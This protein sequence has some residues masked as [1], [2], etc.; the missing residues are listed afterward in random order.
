MIFVLLMAVWGSLIQMG[1]YYRND[2]WLLV[3]LSVAVM[4][5]SI[6]VI[7]EAISVISN[8]KKDGVTGEEAEDTKS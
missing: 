4:I 1:S 2:Q 5:A 7:L 8:L 3:V 6:L